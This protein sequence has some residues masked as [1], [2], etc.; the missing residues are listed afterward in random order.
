M[1]IQTDLNACFPVDRSAD[2]SFFAHLHLQIINLNKSLKASLENSSAQ[3][4]IF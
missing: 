2:L 4:A 3:W 1:E